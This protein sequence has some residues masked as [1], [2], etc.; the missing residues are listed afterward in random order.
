MVVVTE[1]ITDTAFVGVADVYYVAPFVIVGVV[2]LST[3][4][5]WVTLRRYLRV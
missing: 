4:T 2:G 5:S 3:L 1:G